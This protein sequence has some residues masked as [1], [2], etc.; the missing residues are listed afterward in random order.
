SCDGGVCL[1]SAISFTCNNGV[2]EP[3]ELCDGIEGGMDCSYFGFRPGP[4]GCRT[5]CQGTDTS[6]CTECSLAGCIDIT[7]PCEE[8]NLLWASC[9][10][11]E[12]FNCSDFEGYLDTGVDCSNYF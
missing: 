6:S 11:M 12:A 5:D 10:G 8:L 3:G 1:P 7:S 2:L 4:A 9:G